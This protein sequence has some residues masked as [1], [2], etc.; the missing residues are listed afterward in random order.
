MSRLPLHGA[1]LL[2]IIA[3]LVYVAML[4]LATLHAEVPQQAT[5]LA[6]A[7]P[8]D[9]TGEQ[10][11][12][13]ACATCHAADGTGSPQHIVGFRLPLPNGH[14][15]PDFTDCS[16]NT[17][18]PL[19]DWSAVVHRGG[20]IRGLDRHMPAFGDALSEEQI[21][22]I[23]RYV[24]S[25]CRN[26][27]WPHGELNL[28]R[29]F[30]TEKA[31]PEN[32]AVWTSS[33]A[34]SGAKGVSNEL[35]YEHRIG[36]RGQYEITVPLELQQSDD[37]APWVGGLGDIEIAV[38]RTFFADA[39]RG[40]IFAA[41]GAVTLPTG[42]ESQGLGNGF[43]ILEPFAMFGQVLGANGFLQMHGGIEIPT[44]HARGDNEAFLRTALGY[45]LTRDQ[46]FGR[47]WSPMAEVLVAKPWGGTTEWDLVPQV[48]VSLSK[49]QHVLVSAGV[50][51]PLNERDERHPQVVTYLLWD[52]FDGGFFQF[53][54]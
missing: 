8:P 38:R 27:A 43:T 24:R 10:M 13:L 53:W 49:L 54:R 50:R 5:S 25:L 30:F 48:Q 20:R 4:Q 33:I 7:L 19:A 9:A 16:T 42:K 21:D 32:E 34:T 26:S 35:L 12:T 36:A 3:T 41:G 37:G 40:S 22:R 17:P 11:F 1:S 14:G 51:V 31:Y 47:A 52:W 23:L 15:L 28:P 44:D 6:N 46:G 2:V 29:A 18:E 39:A 45:T